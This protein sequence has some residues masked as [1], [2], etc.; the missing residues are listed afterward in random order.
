LKISILLFLLFF[1]NLELNAQ[2]L[3]KKILKSRKER[4]IENPLTPS[5][6]AFY[7]AI[8]PGLGQ[9]F[10]GQAWKVPLVYGAIGSSVYFYSHNKK[11]MNRYR[12]AYKRRSSGFTDD[13]FMEIIPDKTKLLKGMEFHKKYR[14]MSFLF[15]IGTYMLNILDANV[16]AHLMQFNVNDNLSIKSHFESDKYGINSN[17]GLK[18]VVK[19]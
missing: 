18:M 11:E 7:S 12:T 19:L 14:D 16:G 13:E 4:L 17:I 6:A 5:K 3:K 10:I 9:A 15:I 8:I 2:E 1:I